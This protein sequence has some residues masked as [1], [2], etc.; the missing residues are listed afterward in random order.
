MNELIRKTA[1]EVVGLLKSGQVSPLELLDALEERIAEVDPKVNA[2]PTLCFD[3]AR[4]QAE[5]FMADK[6]DKPAH[7]LA[8]LPVVIKDTEDLAGVRTTYGSPIFK[9]HIPVKSNHTVLKLEGN[10]GL[11]YA[12]SNIPEW[13]A[14]AN[15]FNE[16]FGKT[17]NPWDTRMTCAGSSGGSAVALASGMAWSATGS[18][19]GGSLRTPAS[20]CSVVGFRPSPGR[21]P[22]GPQADPFYHM[23]ATGPMGRNVAD[24]AMLLDAMS[25]YVASDPLSLAR[26]A[27]PFVHFA[28]NPDKPVKV[29]FSE[30]LGLTPVDKEVKAVCRAAAEKLAKLGVEVVEAHP[31]LS[32]APEVTQV[33]RAIHFATSM[34]EHLKNHRDL[35]KPEVIWNIEKGLALTAADITR[36]NRL[37]S[38]LIQNTAAF[39]EEYDLLL[40]PAAVVPPF[41]VNIRYVEEVD[42]HKYDN[43]VGWLIITFAITSTLCPS[44]AMPAGFTASGLPVGLQVVGPP[45][46]EA[47]AVSGATILEQELGIVSKTPI[48]PIVKG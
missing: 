38:Q 18:D 41:D 30:D 42:G 6:S 8:G 29:A 47:A 27:T 45:R 32:A 10:G 17:L 33:T 34:E 1:R 48:D 24:A 46:G 40:C 22:R 36:T 14:G 3:R 26:P 20:F 25:G 12:K 28:D 43:Y 44:I 11:P 15:T 35:L 13:A 7:N 2:L 5:A 31:D 37:W 4:K 39:F 21:V 19:L 16:V 9:D 23:V